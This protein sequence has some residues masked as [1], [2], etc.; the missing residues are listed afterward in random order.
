MA[1][2]IILLQRL[3]DYLESTSELKN[4]G[5]KFFSSMD[6][7]VTTK[8]NLPLLLLLILCV[9]DKSQDIYTH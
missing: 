1:C 9:C 4:I 2:L 6:F 8:L 5:T 7:F 3:M